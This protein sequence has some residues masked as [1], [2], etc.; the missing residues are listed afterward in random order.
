LHDVTGGVS[1]EDSFDSE[2]T[3]A[4]PTAADTV[5]LDHSHVMANSASATLTYD[6]G[7]AAAAS[8]NNSHNNPPCY[9]LIVIKPKALDAPQDIPVGAIAFTDEGS[10]PSGFSTDAAFD[11]DFPFLRAPDTEEDGGG[12]G[13]HETHYHNPIAGHTHN[14]LDHSH[15]NYT[16]GYADKTFGYP[17]ITGPTPTTPVLAHHEVALTA[18]GA[19]VSGSQNAPTSSPTYEP[20]W[21]KL[22]IVK[23]T[24]AEAAT[25]DDLV[26]GYVGDVSEATGEIP[27]GWLLMDGD[28]GTTDCLDRHIKATVVGGEVGNTGGADSHTHTWSHSH[29]GPAAHDHPAAESDVQTLYDRVDGATS[30]TKNAIH[31]GH[32]WTISSEVTGASDNGNATVGAADGRQP[33]RTMVFLKRAAAFVPMNRGL[34]AGM[35]ELAGGTQRCK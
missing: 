11:P 22:L 1:D 29:T 18:D 34:R 33:Y 20:A 24:G 16:A 4:R 17:W 3:S 14:V 2:L 9:D 19:G 6:T 28:L 21:V 31:H 30:T 32:T 35:H 12:T 10:A 27:A 23:N 13:N 8:G 25:P 5:T 26:I 7:G 15:D